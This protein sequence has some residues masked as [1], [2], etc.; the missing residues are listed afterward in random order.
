MSAAETPILTPG[1]I[2]EMDDATHI[3]APWDAHK[4]LCGAPIPRVCGPDR[5]LFLSFDKPRPDTW[6]GC[7]GC[8]QAADWLDAREAAP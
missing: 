3:V 6:E 7:W 4:T 5:R 8:L 1:Q 2:A